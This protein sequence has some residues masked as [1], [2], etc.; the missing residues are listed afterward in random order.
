[1]P[2]KTLLGTVM[3]TILL[4]P[5]TT[6][7]AVDVARVFSSNM[8][9]QQGKEVPVW[10]TGEPGERVAVSFGGQIKETNVQS[11]GKWMV[12][13][14]SLTGSREP[15]T[16]TIVGA[17]R[18]EL[19][20]VLVGEVWLAA[21]QSNMGA[22]MVAFRDMYEDELPKADYP[23]VRFYTMPHVAWEG[24]EKQPATWTVCT[25]ETVETFSAVAYFFARALHRARK[26]P[27]GIAVCAWGGT[28]AE[29]WINRE[30]LLASTETAPIVHRYDKTWQA[31]GDRETYL[32]QL[33]AYRDE[34]AVWKK[35]RQAGERPGPRPREP[36]GPRHFR[37]PAGL[38]HTMFR[39]IVPFAFRGIIFYQ[40]ESNALA[41]RSYQYRFLLTKLV[42]RW[43]NDLGDLPFLVVQIPVV[44]GR[45]EDEYAEL[46]ESQWVACQQHDQ[47]ELAVVL[48]FGEYDKL[49]PRYKEGVGERLAALA[50]GVA[51]EEEIVCQG[52]RYRSYHV[53][54]RSVVLQFD[55]MGG[56]LVARNRRLTDFTICDQSKEFIPA[57]AVIRGST[58]VVTAAGV[59]KPVAV[60]YGWNNF[61]DPSLFNEE[62][63]SAS[64]FRTDQFRLKTEGNR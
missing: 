33:A 14:D 37:R 12:R 43:R 38:Y 31:Y 53:D 63:F 56:K 20:N 30:D 52:P 2:R 1:M 35:K 34:L 9:L 62:G 4:L 23:L 55:T 64:P 10:G 8:V 26:E 7:L 59:D 48:E 49:H 36:M 16:M 32:Q 61:F 5:A 11:D 6:A 18:I 47:S 58:V 60:R 22:K 29:N 54:G 42:D 21:G 44:R 41:L 19:Q 28:F 39:S 13:L 45:H 25:P 17:N 40:G 51:Y 3:I 24:D 57:E 46:R 15:R 27:V 50:R